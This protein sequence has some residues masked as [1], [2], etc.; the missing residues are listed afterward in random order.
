[1]APNARKRG[2]DEASVPEQPQVTPG[3]SVGHPDHSFTLQA[4]MELQKTVG[5]MNANLVGM[6]SSVD[7]VKGKVDDL[8]AWKNKI[9]GAAMA[10][11][12]GVSIVTLLLTKSYLSFSAP[13]P[14]SSQG[15]P[16]Q[17]APPAP[18][19]VVQ[20]P[21]ITAPQPRNH[22]HGPASTPSP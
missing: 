1:M 22:Q 21:V 14:A 4:I 19:P 16:V 17:V 12:A 10:V 7:S 18:P 2:A 5:E 9:L 11:G 6:K 8:V 15:T 20:V 3:F 13:A